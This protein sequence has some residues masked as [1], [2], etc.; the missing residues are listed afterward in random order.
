MNSSTQT[1]EQK[2]SWG[3]MLFDGFLKLLTIPVFL[4]AL[5]VLYEL[6]VDAE[7]SLYVAYQNRLGEGDEAKIEVIAPPEAWRE[8]VLQIAVAEI[9]R[10]TLAYQ[11]LWQANTQILELAYRMDD[12]VLQEQLNAVKGTYAGTTF[13][14][15]V[16]DISCGIGSVL[17][18][19]NLQ[20]GCNYA[21]NQRNKMAQ[22]LKS[23]AENHRSSIPKDILN[24][25]P[26]P[27]DLGL[28]EQTLRSIIEEIP[29][30]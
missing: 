21:K 1:A 19:P 2:L 24:G 16:A 11:S 17:G 18:D 5:V 15:N 28:D 25:L 20:Q 27:E 14:T 7:R 9:E 30:E 12:R 22:E 26:K 13:N 29:Y 6:N 3:K 10:R 4:L 8:Q 23:V